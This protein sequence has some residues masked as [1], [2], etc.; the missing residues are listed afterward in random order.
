MWGGG[1]HRER[2]EKRD[3]GA[4]EDETLKEFTNSGVC[5]AVT[6]T[7]CVDIMDSRAASMWVADSCISFIHRRAHSVYLTS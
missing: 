1:R 7:Q 3:R 2:G 6:Q 4:K 5:G